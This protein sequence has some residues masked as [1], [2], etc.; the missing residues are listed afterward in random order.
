LTTGI[1]EMQEFLCILAVLSCLDANQ[2]DFKHLI[3]SS[4]PPIEDLCGLRSTVSRICLSREPNKVTEWANFAGDVFYHRNGLE[5]SVLTQKLY[6]PM[7][8]MQTGPKKVGDEVALQHY[9]LNTAGPALQTLCDSAVEITD[10]CTSG[11]SIGE[12]L[13]NP[14]L[15][16]TRMAGREFRDKRNFD[17]G[18]RLAQLGQDKEDNFIFNSEPFRQPIS[19]PIV[20]GDFKR[21]SLV[22]GYNTKKSLTK[23]T[24]LVKRYNDGERMAVCVVHQ[25][26]GYH[27]Y[28]GCKFGLISTYAETWAT[29]MDD[30]KTLHISQAY[31]ATASGFDSTL[32]QVYYLICL[33]V[34]QLGDGSIR[35]KC[36]ELKIPAH[37]KDFHRQTHKDGLRG[38][39]GIRFIRCMVEHEDRAT[40]HCKLNG[41]NTLVAVKAF[42]D[43]QQRDLELACY[44]AL[45]HLQGVSIP[46]VIDRDYD[47]PESVRRFGLV[48]SWIGEEY[49][50]TYTT[51]PK[52]ALLKA[53][54][55]VLRMHE[56]GVVHRD[57]R[58]GNMHYNFTTGRLFVYDFSHA[59]SLPRMGAAAFAEARQADLEAL[60]GEADRSETEAGKKEVEWAEDWARWRDSDGRI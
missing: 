19:R 56:S 5:E 20:F 26:C 38:G 27:C 8:L 36:P 16:I 10:Y 55:V 57:I 6:Q 12:G 37:A 1:Q 7:P 32:N 60:Q 53:K 28:Y 42:S 39:F 45:L 44:D 31:L 51:L 13:C 23:A 9:F 15:M 3:D 11:Q 40:W 43:K 17:N 54:D 46:T 49:G 18:E 48:L 29:W 34:N 52:G 21:C 22:T 58:T 25:I 41:S 50:G 14:D 59:S 2:I 4:L 24:D 47:E 35:W 30:S 33:A